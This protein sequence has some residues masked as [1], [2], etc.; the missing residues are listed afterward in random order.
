MHLN[1]EQYKA[2]VALRGPGETGY[3]VYLE[4][5]EKWR[6]DRRFAAYL[7]SRLATFTQLIGSSP[8]LQKAISRAKKFADSDRSVWISGERGTGKSALAQAIH[9]AGKRRDQGFY[10]I[11]CG[12]VTDEEWDML[13]T[14]TAQAPGLMEGG[15]AGTLYLKHADRLSRAAQDRWPQ[16]IR[17]GK[18]FRFIASSTTP[19]TKLHHRPEYNQ[20]L[21]T[22]LGEL[23]LSVPPLRDRPEDIEEMIRVMIADYNSRT[24]KQI[25][26]M[27]EAVLERL[28]QYDWPGNLTELENLVQEMMIL[29]KGH[30]TEWDEVSEIWERLRQIPGAPAPSAVMTPIDLSGDLEEIEERI[31]WHVLQEEGMNQSKACKRLGINRSTLWRRLNKM[32]KNET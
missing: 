12:E 9:S 25:V 10:M 22:A 28:I 3:L 31:L 2:T 27:R 24:G 8:T 18:N 13:L 32:F 26:G 15:F 23:H 6:T 4:S 14:G 5:L 19:M 17:G 1:D 21:I 11:S 16:V 7:P 20:E 29:T 30:Y